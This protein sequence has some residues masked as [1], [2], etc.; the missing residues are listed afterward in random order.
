MTAETL[1]SIVSS[2]P[3]DP[4][5][6]TIKA[7]KRIKEADVIL[8]DDLSAGDILNGARN[9]AELVAVGKRAGKRSFKQ[10]HVNQLLVDY[11]RNYPRV[12]RLKSGDA[13]IFGRLEEELRVLHDAN[14]AFEI[15]PGVTSVCAAAAIAQIPLTRRLN[16]RRLQFI[17]GADVSGTLPENLNWTALTD[18]DATTAVYMGRRSFPKLAK[19]LI[20]H[21]L[22]PDTP[23][24]FAESI[25]REGEQLARTT[26][27]ALA[28]TLA[29]EPSTQP[30]LIVYG[31]LMEPL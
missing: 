18:A 20:H 22:A 2:G 28:A 5:L 4:D 3:G 27:A 31:P 19:Q 8:Y 9:D 12:V 25:G 10:Q 29:R 21:G 11:A 6:L 30:T 16:A 13:G 1:V 14:I 23:A 24:L 26:V 17:T 15:I 7:A